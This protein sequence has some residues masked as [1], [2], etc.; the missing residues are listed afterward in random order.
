MRRNVAKGTRQNDTVTSGK[1]ISNKIQIKKDGDCLI[2]TQ[3][4]AK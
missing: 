4:I 1:S 2:K 3:G